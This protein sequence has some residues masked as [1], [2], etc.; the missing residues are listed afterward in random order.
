MLRKDP[1][2]FIRFEILLYMHRVLIDE[3]V[4]LKGRDS[5]ISSEL[6]IFVITAG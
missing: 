5:A 3:E 1:V 6:L 4:F 2:L